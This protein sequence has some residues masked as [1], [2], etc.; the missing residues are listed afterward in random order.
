MAWPRVRF[1][2]HGNYCGP[3]HRV[4]GSEPVSATDCA[5]QE[6]DRC[7]ERA[8]WSDCDCDARLVARCRAIRRSR[9]AWRSESLGARLANVAIRALFFTRKCVRR[10]LR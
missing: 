7:Y 8:G 1:R 6:H 10:A 2:L 5:C 3:G 4:P 9:T